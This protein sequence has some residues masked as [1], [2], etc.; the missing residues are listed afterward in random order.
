MIAEDVLRDRFPFIEWD[1]PQRIVIASNEGTSYY[2]YACR[3]CVA[4][5]GLRAAAVL[6]GHAA[7]WADYDEAKQHIEESHRPAE[8]T[9]DTGLVP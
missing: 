7:A 3:Y 4:Q 5:K 6:E 8:G 9:T 2:A 1:E